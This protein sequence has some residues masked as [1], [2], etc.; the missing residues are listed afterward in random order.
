MLSHKHMWKVAIFI[1]PLV[2]AIVLVANSETAAQTA[3]P[4]A[5]VQIENGQIISFEPLPSDDSSQTPPTSTLQNTG[6]SQM[7]SPLAGP[8]LVLTNI[9]VLDATG[10]VISYQGTVK[11]QGDEVAKGTIHNYIYLSQNTLISRKEDYKIG[12]WVVSDAILLPLTSVTSP[13][14]MT[15]VDNSVPTGNYYLGVIIDAENNIAETNELNNTG[16]AKSPLVSI[17]EKLP[18]LRVKSISISDAYGPDL[19]Y[20]ITIGNYGNLDVTGSVHNYVYLSLNTTISPAED[21]KIDDWILEKTL[22]AG[23]S[24]SSSTREVTVSN[25]PDNKYYLG[26]FTDAEYKW[27]ESD[28]TNNTLYAASPIVTIPLAPPDPPVLINP[29]NGRIIYDNQPLFD[30]NSTEEI[31][32]WDI[33]VDDH[34]DFSSPAIAVT[35]TENSFKPGTPL[36]DG[37]WYWRV[38]ARNS[39]GA[40]LWSAAWAFTILTPPEPVSLSAPDNGCE[41]TDATPAFFWK[42]TS[43]AD[44]YYFEIDDNA[45]FSSPDM[46]SKTPDT[47]ITLVN[48]LPGGT[49]YWRVQAFNAAGLGAYSAVWHIILIAP[50]ATP[51]LISPPNN[52]AISDATP[53]FDWSRVFQAEGY[54]LQIDSSVSFLTPVI[55][56]SSIS[57]DLILPAE[58]P[59]GDW[60]WRARANNRAGSSAWSN[61]W[62]FRLML[63]LDTPT[64]RAPQ[65]NLSIMDRTP[66]FSWN[67]VEDADEYILQV[68]DHSDFSSP[69]L[70]TTSVANSI[71][72]GV[73]LG[74]GTWYWRIKAQGAL[75]ESDWSEIWSFAINLAPPRIYAPRDKQQVGSR[76]GRVNLQWYSVLDALTYRVQVDN[77]TQF[78]SPNIDITTPQTTH[79]FIDP[80]PFGTWFWRVKSSNDHYAS[81]WSEVQEF[82]MYFLLDVPRLISP[83]NDA[84]IPDD[85]TPTFIWQTVQNAQ[86]YHFQLADD[87]HENFIG[88]VEIADSAFTLTTVL[89]PQKKYFWRVHALG[90]MAASPWSD[91]WSFETR[92]LNLL[93]P[94][95]VSPH[96][97]TTLWDWERRPL[98]T[99]NPVEGA[100]G[101]EIKVSPLSEGIKTTAPSFQWQYPLDPLA[102]DTWYTWQVRS[103]HDRDQSDWSEAFRFSMIPPPQIV[104]LVSPGKDTTISDQRPAFRWEVFSREGHFRP[105]NFTIQIHNHDD[106]IR[107]VIESDILG[108]ETG[109]H[110]GY[111]PTV[112]WPSENLGYGTWY[113]RVRPLGDEWTDAWSFT[114]SQRP[115]RPI[116]L[117]PA[118]YDTVLDNSP[119]FFWS[120]VCTATAYDIQISKDK[121]F[122][123]NAIFT[124]TSGT[125]YS[126]AS[127]SAGTWFWRV[128][129]RNVAGPGDWSVVFRFEILGASTLGIPRRYR[130]GEGDFLAA[131]PYL[132]AW[133]DIPEATYY[134][135]QIADNSFFY[136]PQI[137]ARANTLVYT[138]SDTLHDGILFWRVR[139]LNQVMVGDWSEGWYFVAGAED[140]NNPIPAL[141]APR[142]HFFGQEAPQD[143]SWSDASRMGYYKLQISAD[144]KF[145]ALVVDTVVR[146]LNY[147]LTGDVGPGSWYWRVCAGISEFEDRDAQPSH[148]DYWGMWSESWEFT[149][150]S[151]LEKL[152]LQ[153]PINGAEVLNDEIHLMWKTMEGIPEYEVMIDTDQ[154]FVHPLV[155]TRA[156]QSFSMIDGSKLLGQY[157]WKVRPLAGII[158]GQWSDIWIFSVTT[159]GVENLKS[160]YPTA[161]CLYQNYPNPFNTQTVFRFYLPQ[162][163]GVELDIYSATGG[164]VKT[165][166]NNQPLQG[167]QE[168]KWDGKDQDGRTAASGLYFCCLRA[169]DHKVIQK[170]L[171]LK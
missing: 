75:G 132:F 136:A 28:E 140:R 146:V 116:P 171:L 4:L 137:Q 145:Q 18:D 103:L 47:Q 48:P 119:H 45:G 169:G 60:Y 79:T 111:H 74:L 129:A 57:D 123:T 42:G 148:G 88:D 141:I 144:L 15:T 147:R 23:T 32:S 162:K 96:D 36:Y 55:N 11:N 43:K 120:S 50:P 157:F 53:A 133:S 84:D 72:A 101:Y 161:F 70:N 135:I 107:P 35:L 56:L 114:I 134:D 125:D 142:N 29:A 93:P 85:L 24:E 3:Q 26:V 121:E 20:I 138:H 112:Y 25:V 64:L 118:C 82:Y 160:C 87:T 77:N 152:Q 19:S 127:L 143:Y 61:P 97:D 105:S 10:P 2:S 80:L 90:E 8:D 126:A 130:P 71:E 124:S 66:F 94:V 108:N 69:A 166:I 86:G 159:A 153:S 91:T 73:M 117:S 41:L 5:A 109:T 44:G 89:Q 67:E 13:I 158:I 34:P 6:Q 163:C 59:R 78:S 164:H 106:F 83:A 149:V 115:V 151:R 155:Q 81:A 170:V 37:L 7:D 113:W 168:S 30:W 102:W 52:N 27:D 22:A 49:F 131:S 17:V 167:L 1:V 38:R 99:W 9:S 122:Q 139:A 33:H 68:D 150:E 128:R 16:Y 14:V 12:D 21:Y 40:G 39:A 95:L 165:L 98:F 104:L 76:D 156:G 154:S 110:T 54:D 31:I 65:N 92:R 51:V 58:L 100:T 46:R 63:Q 62:A